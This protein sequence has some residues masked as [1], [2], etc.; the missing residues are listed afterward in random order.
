[1][2]I[3]Y[4]IAKRY[5]VKFS[6]NSAINS[7]T[8]IASIAI[9]ASAMALF[10]FLSVFSGL[11]DFTLQFSNT[12]DPDFKIEPVNGKS[13]FISNNELLKLEY[14]TTIA[15]Y[16]KV[17]EERALL[18]FGDKEIITTFAGVDKNYVKVCKV[19]EY[20]Y[21]GNWLGNKTPQVVVGSEIARKLSL[22]LYDYTNTLEVFVPKAG[23]G[24][25][26]TKEDGFFSSALN[27]VGIFNINEEVDAKYTYCDYDFCRDLYNFKPNQVSYIVVK[28]KP[29]FKEK[30]VIAEIHKILGDKVQVKTRA[31]LN[32]SLYK[33]LNS[34][35]L[36]IYLFSTLV[37]I[38][39]LFCLSGA[40]V[41]IIIDKKENILTLYNIG[42][43]FSKIRLIFFLQGVIIT[44]FGLALGLFLGSI[45][46]L[47]QQNYEF[48][49]ITEGIPYPVAFKITNILLVVVTILVL[50]FLSS[51]IASGRVK[52]EIFD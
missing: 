23:K 39:T 48:L 17:I 26:E 28:N 33:M 18:Y 43:P 50:G 35:N 13:F 24:L 15:N 19:D 27:T 47:L 7:I 51:W 3:S 49:M 37:V 36:F 32:E 1:M 14:A 45:L 8:L 46:I 11:R 6:N 31:Q 16:S 29:D 5:A 12:S 9:I 25:I 22:G 4:Y 21:I 52:K 40:I 41:M 42:L 2:N 44:C 38:L 30:Q 20:L 34:E 10:I